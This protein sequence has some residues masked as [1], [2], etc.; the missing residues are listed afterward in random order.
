MARLSAGGL[1]TSFV[2]QGLSAGDIPEVWNVTRRQSVRA[3]HA[4]FLA[5]GSDLILTN[6]FGANPPRLE[7][8]RQAD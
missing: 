3:A 2:A 4:T 6:S 1:G 8:H 5:A 7:L